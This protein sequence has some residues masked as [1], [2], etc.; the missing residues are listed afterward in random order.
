MRAATILR[1]AALSVALCAA[2]PV[3]AQAATLH[4]D[5]GRID[6]RA[7]AGER[8]SL[9]VVTTPSHFAQKRP[10]VVTDVVAITATGDCVNVDAR[11]ARCP[12]IT[13]GIARLGDQDDTALIQVASLTVLGG[14]GDDLFH[15]GAAPVPSRVLYAGDGGFDTIDYA[16]ANAG[17]SL[18]ADNRANDGRPGDRDGTFNVEGLRGSAFG[19]VISG[20]DAGEIIE[21]GNGGD[22]IRAGGGMDTIVEGRFRGSGQTTPNGGDFLSGG[23]G[24]DGVV[25]RD[26]LA[27]VSVTFE[28]RTDIQN[29]GAAGEGDNVQDDVE[30]VEGGRGDDTLGTSPF[31]GLAD[32][33][34]GDDRLVGGPGRD[35]LIGGPGVDTLGGLGGND[36]LMTADGEFDI[37]DCGTDIDEIQ[38]DRA[39]AAFGCESNGVVGTFRLAPR[40]LTVRPG[41]ASTVTIRWTH[42]ARWTDLDE[43][44]LVLRHGGRRIGEVTVDQETERVRSHGPAVRVL[45]GRSS[46]TAAGPFARTATL[47]LAVRFARRYAGRTLTVEVGAT[48]D[49]GVRQA[50]RRAGAL[51]IAQR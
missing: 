28:G 26:R 43:V 42:P 48:G 33:G 37:A 46:L 15:A 40:T 8:N 4:G 6:Y 38:R 39:D 45:P 35:V 30:I 3:A 24:Q 32:G 17:V 20:G 50:P 18:S 7:G 10:D 11:T 23:P 27:P 2:A 51:R 34:R 14:D 49:G 22:V 47:R 12:S 19:D 36:L 9:R 25:Y 29:D 44:R 21:G 1:A 31:G 13:G 41:Q 16:S 5:G